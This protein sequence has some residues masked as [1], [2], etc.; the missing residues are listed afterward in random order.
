M[1]GTRPP[2]IDARGRDYYVDDAL[3]ITRIHA[4]KDRIDA[5]EIDFN[6][7]SLTLIFNTHI[8]LGLITSF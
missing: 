6:M 1:G 7:A 3:P 5:C 4:L 2:P 8:L